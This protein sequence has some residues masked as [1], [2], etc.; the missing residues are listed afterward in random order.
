M[1]GTSTE[2]YPHWE[3][4]FLLTY[5]AGFSCAIS[6]VAPMRRAVRKKNGSS[7]SGRAS[8]GRTRVCWTADTGKGSLQRM[9]CRILF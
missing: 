9:L 1:A 5:T 6:S 2:F 7:S 8:K 4:R 3:T